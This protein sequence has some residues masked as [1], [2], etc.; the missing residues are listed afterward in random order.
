M[1]KIWQSMIIINENN[2]VYDEEFELQ[3]KSNKEKKKKTEERTL[4]RNR[5]CISLRA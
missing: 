1:P 3:R 2:A 5:N 4:T